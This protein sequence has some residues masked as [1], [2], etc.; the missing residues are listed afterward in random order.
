MN[1]IPKLDTEE[2][3]EPPPPLPPRESTPPPL[4]NKEP[5]VP[6]LPPKLTKN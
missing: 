2:E 6:A 5:Q 1:Y 3:N 4:L